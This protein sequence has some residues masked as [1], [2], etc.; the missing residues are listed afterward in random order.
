MKAAPAKAGAAFF[1]PSPREPALKDREK[2]V[3][4]MG[5]ENTEGRIIA[6]KN[7]GTFTQWIADD[8]ASTKTGNVGLAKRCG[9]WQSPRPG[10]P[11]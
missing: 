5:R 4:A 10:S 1:L 3:L 2:Q 11:S 9:R 6:D 7:I 8:D